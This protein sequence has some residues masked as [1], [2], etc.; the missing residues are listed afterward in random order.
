M[1]QRSTLPRCVTACVYVHGRVR[2][3]VHMRVGARVF[4]CVRASL[5]APRTRA[6]AHDC[7]RRRP[8]TARRLA[9]LLSQLYHNCAGLCVHVCRCGGGRAI[10][11]RVWRVCATRAPSVWPQDSMQKHLD[12]R[13]VVQATSELDR[14]VS[15]GKFAVDVFV[16]KGLMADTLSGSFPTL[17]MGASLK[18]DPH[19]RSFATMPAYAPR[20]RRSA[21]PP[22]RRRSCASAPRV[23]VSLTLP[24]VSASSLNRPSAR[25]PVAQHPA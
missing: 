18:G 4:F 12:L 2:M 3:R 1:C 21:A 7:A 22:P 9:R 19:S 8:P 23:C 17:A 10:Y 5:A 13:P 20:R 25:L 11:A 24:F 6:A 15:E 14:D 16:H